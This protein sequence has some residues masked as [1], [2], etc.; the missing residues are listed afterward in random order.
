LKAGPLRTVFLFRWPWATCLLAVPAVMVWLRPSAAP[1]LLYERP[2]ILQGEIWRLWTGHW[3]H[4]SGAHLFW[5]L[6]VLLPAGIWAEQLAPKAFRIL[7]F[8]SAGIIGATLLAFDPMLTRYGGLSGIAAAA[9]AFLALTRFSARAGDR[10]FWRGVLVLL[11]L[12]VGID[13]SAHHSL[14]AHLEESGIQTVPLAH[15]GGILSA[16]VVHAFRHRRQI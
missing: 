11:A 16:V 7:C 10:W 13:L 8:L 4:F 15:L 1:A 9:L 2:A 12:K 6:A 3:V 5:N 14:L